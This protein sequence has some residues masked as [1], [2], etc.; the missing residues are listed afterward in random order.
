MAE[1]QSFMLFH[2][3]FFLKHDRA[4]TQAHPLQTTFDLLL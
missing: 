1:D 2:Y 3:F 4:R